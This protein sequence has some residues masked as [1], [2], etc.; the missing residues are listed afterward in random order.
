MN[1]L[2]YKYRDNK[3][4]KVTVLTKL[5]YSTLLFFLIFLLSNQ[6]FPIN[7]YKSYSTTI[8]D[9]QG[10]ILY[11]FLSKDEKWRMFTQ[12]NEISEELKKAIIYKEDKFFYWHYGVNPIAMSRALFNNIIKQKRTSG[13]STI[14]MQVVRLLNP[15]PRTYGNKI[16]E[17]FRAIQLEWKLSKAEILQ[18]YL[19]LVPYGG[20]IE[21][22]KSASVLYFN[23]MPNHLSLAEITALSIIPNKPSSLQIG[24][25]NEE[26][27]KERNKWLH[28]FKKSKLF[29]I[30][31]IDDALSE[32]F[33]AKRT[34]SPK[35]AP[36]LA[37]RLKQQYPNEKIIKTTLKKDKQLAAEKITST[38]K[39]KLLPY[40][41]YNSAVII[42]DNHLN[43]VVAYVGSADFYSSADA[44]QVDGIRAIRQPGSTLKPLIYAMAFNNGNLTPKTVI[45]DVPIN[46]NGYSPVNFNQE[47]NGYVTAENALAKSLNIPAVKALNM[48]GVENVVNKLMQCKFETIEKQKDNLGLSLVLGGCGVTLEEMTSLYAAF[49]NNGNY[50]TPTYLKNS[51]SYNTSTKILN[52]EVVFMINEILTKVE[53]PDLPNSWQ[54]AKNLP[55]ISWKTGTSYGRRDAWSIGYNDNYTIGVWVGNFSGKGVPELTGAEMA[56]PLLFNL[57]NEIE[58][59]SHK[60]WIKAPEKLAFRLVCP[61]T[62]LPP[63]EN[64]EHTIMDYFIP[65][66]SSNLKCNH[67]QKYY[68]SEND[69]FSYCMTCLPLA[70]YK[71]KWLPNHPIEMLAYFE[72]HQINYTKIPTHNPYCTSF[73]NFN[74][75]QIATPSEGNTYYIIK[76]EPEALVLSAYT[77]SDVKKIYWYVNNQFLKEA[78]KTE[79]VLYT[80]TQSGYYKISCSDDKARNSDIEIEVKV[81]D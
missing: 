20:N 77:A 30:T 65:S 11:S 55:K 72:Q 44:G 63:S 75:P 19:N 47:F 56:S 2:K 34:T 79:K 16:F 41:I 68:I 27:E 22:V 58:K 45:T 12:L 81:V 1:L 25:H 5:C 8:V 46:Y 78:N 49:A 26:I 50:S 61:E 38:Y 71:E 42:I 62:G 57:F 74:P 59:E 4:T 37:F 43:E 15:K 67:L 52:E 24:V 32:P 70:G 60:N 10:E 13:A 73:N 35:I 54:T 39:N 23:K 48:V 14:S 36:H 51:K 33:Y 64:C 80:P 3:N 18:L 69:S 17:I 76:E 9:S 21:G 66:I 29:N 53:R 7:I 28:T 40:N 6:V 31:T